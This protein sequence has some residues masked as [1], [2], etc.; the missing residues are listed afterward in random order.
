M[1]CL[2][3][4]KCSFQYIPPY[5]SISF[6]LFDLIF[7]NLT[8][9]KWYF[10]QVLI[11]V[12]FL[13]VAILAHS[14]ANLLYIIF[15]RFSILYFALILM[16]HE[17]LLCNTTGYQSFIGCIYYKYLFPICGLTFSLYVPLCFLSKLY[18]SQ[19]Y[20]SFNVY[21]ISLRNSSIT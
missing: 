4:S 16:V 13:L 11:H 7:S 1:E 3:C 12:P 9:M 20:Q 8:A 5:S 19:I 17:N 14:S 15:A 6:T 10:I 2:Q 21:T 18:C